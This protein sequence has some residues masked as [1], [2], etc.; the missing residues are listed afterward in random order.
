MSILVNDHEK[1]P[2]ADF[3][4]QDI[5]TLGYVH[6]NSAKIIWY[7]ALYQSRE[8]RLDF[9]RTTYDLTDV[10][11]VGNSLH[12]SLS[13]RLCMAQLFTLAYVTYGRSMHQF[14]QLEMLQL[15]DVIFWYIPE[16]MPNEAQNSFF[17]E[18]SALALKL[19]PCWQTILGQISARRRVTNCEWALTCCDMLHCLVLSVHSILSGENTTFELEKKSLD[20]A[21]DR[22]YE[23]LRYTTISVQIS[24]PLREEMCEALRWGYFANLSDELLKR[25]KSLWNALSKESKAL[26]GKRLGLIVPKPSM[27]VH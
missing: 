11:R 16:S 13:R 18:D 10:L 21:T 27:S 15:Q 26:Q 7:H 6:T 22:L 9:A 19:Q 20:I 3:S 2:P 17:N 1:A 4:K 25:C 23:K 12:D 8:S 24:I 14:G 5:L